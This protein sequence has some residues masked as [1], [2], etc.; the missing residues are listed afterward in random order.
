MAR[1]A[2]PITL[3]G[4][5]FTDPATGNL[6]YGNVNVVPGRPLYLYG[7][8]Y[9]GGRALN[10]GPNTT[11]ATAALVA[12]G[13]GTGNAARN[14]LRGFGAVQ[15]NAAARREFHLYDNFTMQFRAEAFNILNHPN[16]GYVD[17]TL[18]NATFG[19]ATKMLNASLGTVAAQ[20]QQGGPRSL[21]FALKLQF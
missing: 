19:T 6:N 21:Q 10:G 18:T 13:T 16:F 2:F 15:V 9:S 4:S 20:Y 11:A 5:L 12:A 8:Q 1:T 7:S 17:P 14:F 3:Q